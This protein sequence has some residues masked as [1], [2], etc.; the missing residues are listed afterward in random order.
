MYFWAMVSSIAMFIIVSLLTCRQSFNMEKLLHRGKYAVADD[1]MKEEFKKRWSWSFIIGIDRHFT[2]GDKVISVS[3]FSWTMFWW[4]VFIIGTVWNIM[5]PWPLSW[6]ATYWKYYA[7]V[8]PLTIGVISTIWFL[9]GGIHDLHDLYV[10]L[11][12]YKSDVHDDG[13][14]T[15]DKEEEQVLPDNFIDIAEAEDETSDD[16][17]PYPGKPS[18]MD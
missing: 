5:D 12:T 6:W 15:H 10:N 16:P 3:V 1:K 8:I 13:T 14:V 11:K 18:R 7:I 2:W 4:V 9:W 17:K